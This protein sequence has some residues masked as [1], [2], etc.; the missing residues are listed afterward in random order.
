[1]VVPVLW[2]WL[3]AEVYLIT[4]DSTIC[5]RTYP[6]HTGLLLLFFFSIFDIQKSVSLE[7]RKMHKNVQRPS[8]VLQYQNVMGNNVNLH[9]ERNI[10]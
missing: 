4:I 9:N 6:T 3:C 5:T 1:M 8:G 10:V 2:H 7:I